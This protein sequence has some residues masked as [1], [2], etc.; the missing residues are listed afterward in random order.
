MIRNRYSADA[1]RERDPKASTIH[2]RYIM[3][4]ENCQS[5]SVVRRF[6]EYVVAFRSDE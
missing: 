1:I 5:N 3:L 4:N 6:D 2:G